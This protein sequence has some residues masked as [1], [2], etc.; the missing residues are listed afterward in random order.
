MCQHG[1]TLSRYSGTC[2]KCSSGISLTSA[3]TLVILGVL[4]C[5]GALTCRLYKKRKVKKD[6]SAATSKQKLRPMLKGLF[7]FVQIMSSEYSTFLFV[8]YPRVFV[9]VMNP[10]TFTFNLNVEAF[11]GIFCTKVDHYAELVVTT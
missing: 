2:F 7:I 9:K 11:V 6:L 4:A 10:L 3:G 1:Y 8:S 5:V